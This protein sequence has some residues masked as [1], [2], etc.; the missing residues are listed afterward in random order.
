[1]SNAVKIEMKFVVDALPVEL[2]GMNSA[3]MCNYIT[4]CANQLLLSLGCNHH[5]KVGNPFEC[6]LA[7]RGRQTSLRSK[8]GN[9]PNQESV[10]TMRINTLPS[11][12]VSEMK[13]ND[14]HKIHQNGKMYSLKYILKHYPPPLH[15][16]TLK[17]L[18]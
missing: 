16:F 2:I 5:Y 1:M 4:F 3:M 13:W 7:Y 11:T 15:V 8:L 10:L 12:L 17:A 14:K 18:Q 9:T 6:I